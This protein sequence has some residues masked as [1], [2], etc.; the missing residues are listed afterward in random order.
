MIYD[1]DLLQIDGETISSISK[2]KVGRHKLWRD[3]ERKTDD[4]IKARFRG[5][6]PDITVEFIPL[7][8][9]EMRKII[10][11][12]DKPYVKLTWY[13]ERVGKAV[14]GDYYNTSYDIELKSKHKMTYKPFEYVFKPIRRKDY[15]DDNIQ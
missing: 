12:I 9:L 14:T 4:T 5:I 2:Y 13:D 3:A 7:N 6:F 10:N 11:I 15:G 8:A 1:G